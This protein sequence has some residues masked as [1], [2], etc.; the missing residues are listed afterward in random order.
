M[1]FSSHAI[2]KEYLLNA[3]PETV[4]E[5]IREASQEHKSKFSDVLP[6]DLSK[7]LLHR[8]EPLIN[9]ALAEFTNDLK[10]LQY[11]WQFY[12]IKTA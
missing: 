10:I 11:V 8:N 3:S 4:Y 7:M 12:R 6:E 1:E 5:F 9:L 2:Q